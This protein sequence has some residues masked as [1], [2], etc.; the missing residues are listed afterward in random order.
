MIGRLKGIL[1][2]KKPPTVAINV[3]GVTYELDVSMNTIFQLPDIGAEVA[4]HTHLM[5]RDDAHLLYGFYSDL[6][7]E[8]FRVLLKVNGVGARTAMAVLGGMTAEELGTVVSN[9]DTDRLTMVPGIGKKTAE[10]MVL[11]LK[12]R[13]LPIQTRPKLEGDADTRD[14]VLAALLSLG[15]GEKEVVKVLNQIDLSQSLPLV[16]KEAL[17]FFT[18]PR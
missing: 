16:I 10:R 11:E 12:D 2:S 13:V 14:D 5:I 6:E 7:K 18:A 17:K 15:Y 1:E 3:G 8:M 9:R 4:L